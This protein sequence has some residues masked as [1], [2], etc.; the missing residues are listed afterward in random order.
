MSSDIER[1]NL[2]DTPPTN[3]KIENS[4]IPKKKTSEK[5]GSE[6]KKQVKLTKAEAERADKMWLRHKA[7]IMF[8]VVVVIIFIIWF[9][10]FKNN[11]DGTLT[12]YVARHFLALLTLIVGYLFG[13]R[14]K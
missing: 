7:I 4:T 10:D 6:Q 5:V 8:F 12:E 13:S 3:V 1:N 9:L 2:V 14:E 11:P